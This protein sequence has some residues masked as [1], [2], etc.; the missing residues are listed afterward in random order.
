LGWE[1]DGSA[2]W[3]L[4][5]VCSIG[6]TIKWLLVQGTAQNKDRY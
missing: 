2:V 5:A 1:S 3:A 4:L 6:K